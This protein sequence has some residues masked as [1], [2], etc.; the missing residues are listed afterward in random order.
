MQDLNTEAK[1]LKHLTEE[2]I[3]KSWPQSN[4]EAFYDEE[5]D[6]EILIEDHTRNSSR[7]HWFKQN[8]IHESPLDTTMITYH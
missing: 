2:V 1:Y 5:S 4:I 3:R 8:F 6:W 7:R